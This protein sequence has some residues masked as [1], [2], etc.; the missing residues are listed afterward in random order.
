MERFT[1]QEIVDFFLHGRIGKCKPKHILASL[2]RT[3]FYTVFGD[4]PAVDWDK[5]LALTF[6]NAPARL[7]SLT[8]LLE[9][10]LSFENVELTLI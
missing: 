3:R 5:N 2:G 6:S 9:R 1:R 10:M 4:E 7:L 8:I